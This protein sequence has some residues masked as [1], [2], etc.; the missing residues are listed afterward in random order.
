MFIFFVSFIPLGIYD[1][2]TGTIN[3]TGKADSA[4]IHM[5]IQH[6]NLI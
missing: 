3:R 6:R 5:S 2:T 4:E 1:F